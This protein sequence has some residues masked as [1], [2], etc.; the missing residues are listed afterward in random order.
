MTET[1]V[2]AEWLRGLDPTRRAALQAEIRRKGLQDDPRTICLWR[3]PG[4]CA[5]LSP[6]QQQMLVLQELR[7]DNSGY[8]TFT[9]L[10]L[11]GGGE[12]ASPA[13]LAAAFNAMAQRHEVL[14][15]VYRHEDDRP[16]QVLCQGTL[17]TEV[18]DL[19]GVRPDEAETALDPVLRQSR[20]R[21][22]D[23]SVDWPIRPVIA[24]LDG[25][26]VA[27][28]VTIHHIA[29]DGWSE[30]VFWSELRSLVDGSADALEDLPFQY[31]DYSAWQHEVGI[32]R[33]LDYWRGLLA[34][35]PEGVRLARHRVS[36]P[37]S[38]SGM[39]HR[40]EFG[41]VATADFRAAIA[42]A[43]AT[44]HM[45]MVAALLMFMATWSG[46]DDVVLGSP[47]ANRQGEQS[48]RLIGNFVNSALFRAVVVEGSSFGEV[49]RL[50]R[51]QAVEA[52]ARPIPLGELVRALDPE[53]GAGDQPLYNVNLTLHNNPE[54]TG[55]A[56][57]LDIAL[58]APPVAASRF[59][60][61]VNLWEGEHTITGSLLHRAGVLLPAE[62][63]RCAE[64]F[65]RFGSA[66]FAD[67]DSPVAVVRERAEVAGRAAAMTLAERIDRVVCSF[68]GSVAVE[69]H[70]QP[71]MTFADLDVRVRSL[72]D[73]L[74]GVGVDRGSRVLIDAGRGAE[75]IT[76]MLAC[77]RIGAAYTPVDP[78]DTRE[79]VEQISTALAPHALITRAADD[80][81][82]DAPPQVA[83]GPGDP[84]N[85]TEDTAYVLFTSGTTGVP[86]GVR[87]PEA[88]LVNYAD[89]A[90]L[91]YRMTEGLGVPL[92]TS[93][94]VDLTVTSI[95]ATLLAGQRVITFADEDYPGQTV[96]ERLPHLRD[97]TLVKLTPTHLAMTDGLF[98]RCPHIARTLV[99]GGEALPMAGV[100]PIAWRGVRVYNE[101]G[102]T[103]ATVACVATRLSGH[104]DG[105]DAP[106]GRPIAGAVVSVLGSA[107]DPVP[108]GRVGELVVTGPGVAHGYLDAPG[109]T[110]AAFLPVADGRRGYATGD[111]VHRDIA[112]G[113]L[114]FVGRADRQVKIR[115]RR[116][117]LDEIA[118]IACGVEGIRHAG[119]EVGADGRLRLDLVVDPAATI[120]ASA[121]VKPAEG[122]AAVLGDWRAVFDHTYADGD[123]PF[124]GWADS[125]CQEPIPAAHMLEWVRQTVE[126]ITSAAP[127]PEPRVLEIGCGTGLLLTRL[128]PWSRSYHATDLSRSA[129]E[130]IRALLAE[131]DNV[132]WA[133]RVVLSRQGADVVPD[134]EFDVVVLNSVAQYFPS[135]AY[136]DAVLDALL[137]RLSPNGVL[138]LG[139]LRPAELDGRLAWWIESRRDPDPATLAARVA[140]RVAGDPELRVGPD[141]LL[142]LPGRLVRCIPKALDAET[143]MGEFRFDC[144]IGPHGARHAP[145]TVVAE[146]IDTLDELDAYL[147]DAP[148]VLSRVRWHGS[149]PSDTGRDGAGPRDTR[150]TGVRPARLAAVARRRGLIAQFEIAPGTGCEYYAVRLAASPLPG[151]ILP[152]VPT[153]S[154]SPLVREP[155]RTL[156]SR[157]DALAAVVVDAIVRRLGEWARPS[158]VAVHDRVVAAAGGKAAPRS[159]PTAPPAT[160]SAPAGADWSR[161]EPAV[162]RLLGREVA[163]TDHFFRAGGHSLLAIQLVNTLRGELGADIPMRAP[164]DHP[165]LQDLA[166]V[167]GAVL[168]RGDAA[169]GPG[170]GSAEDR[171]PAEAPL[172]V[173]QQG[174]WFD[175]VT[176]PNSTAMNMPLHG[177]LPPGTGLDAVVGALRFLVLRHDVL[178]VRIRVKDGTP[179][180]WI[181][182][183]HPPRI[184]VVD[185]AAL[186]GGPA[187]RAAADLAAAQVGTPFDLEAE[188]P[189]RIAVLRLP[190]RLRVL[191]TVHHVAFD[192]TSEQILLDGAAAL[193]ARGPEVG[194]AEAGSYLAY[195]KRQAESDHT[196]ST[197]FWV[198]RLAGVETA[199]LLPQREQAAARRTRCRHERALSAPEAS[200]LRAYADIHGTTMYG[201]L[202]AAFA[203]ALARLSERPDVVMAIDYGGRPPGAE[204]TVGLFVNQLLLRCSMNTGREDTGEGGDGEASD[205][206]DAACA[207]VRARLAEAV[208]HGHAPF[209][210][211]VQRLRRRN[212]E[213]ARRPFQVKVSYLRHDRPDDR[214][215]WQMTPGLPGDV[216]DGVTFLCRDDG[217]SV[218]VIAEYAAEQFAAETVDAVLSAWERALAPALGAAVGR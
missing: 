218:T 103:E 175:Q 121:E 54:A 26:A 162:R 95:I 123:D 115:G 212:K 17:V 88:A 106:I 119:A 24:L 117:E 64:E 86:K 60:L 10:R 73:Q 34:G 96:V 9:S 4:A 183:D 76:A 177:D 145:G 141:R 53:R 200:A 143:E 125:A 70:G 124:A 184:D 15:T 43:G 217:A 120:E 168:A 12:L 154:L 131:P 156:R 189:V 137:S 18:V 77:L 161:I 172:T 207:E 104:E 78:G 59:D 31:A 176:S 56:A 5:P 11:S 80:A 198:E 179:V 74:A 112:T 99:L 1:P 93:L 190:D 153:S 155:A 160:A 195:A 55:S 108:D 136:F 205:G 100:R 101:Y 67:R 186:N 7:P 140:A 206:L 14:R 157:Q 113:D 182:D 152:T 151:S 127:T 107:G 90:A 105:D 21:G 208:E 46:D 193:A 128:A 87:V 50:V 129:V 171:A 146:E 47:N 114:H 32:G 36:A 44:P 75:A 98:E 192:G 28:A 134:G 72:A 91:E 211:V 139:D 62:G 148:V 52:V 197:D 65:V 199:A 122:D 185:L 118:V 66:L 111:R 203:L 138:F 63:A 85:S 2:R 204:N 37:T 102:P 42:A 116:V 187:R 135:A 178:R 83:P 6:A 92:V 201:V 170:A 71:P 196:A 163:P 89:W 61:D 29:F 45:G 94:S 109:A 133:D 39:S 48:R 180:Q 147:G 13:R 167:V 33:H 25:D 22:F 181:D 27:L 81:G 142:S 188:P 213:L 164:F 159:T 23:L 209:S 38:E 215:G 84:E 41:P 68:P 16:V 79:R 3:E 97:L 35:A 130:R 8:H 132:E 169:A 158:E 191:M 216:G 69:R 51:E 57:G 82:P 194:L 40:V 149:D 174:V 126:R 173:E 58:V 210:A 214:G 202:L 165:V 30:H 20:T 150:R 49:L 144:V 166:A 110:A 19:R